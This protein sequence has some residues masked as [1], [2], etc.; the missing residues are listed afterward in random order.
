MKK[1]LSRVID[2]KTEKKQLDEKTTKLKITNRVTTKPQL[3]CQCQASGKPSTE[4]PRGTRR[5][6]H[7]AKKHQP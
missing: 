2:I 3:F 5:A 4:F 1:Q 7:I 6:D